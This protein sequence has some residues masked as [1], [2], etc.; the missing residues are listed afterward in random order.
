[1]SLPW[2]RCTS[3]GW[4]PTTFPSACGGPNSVTE[5]KH[6]GGAR[7]GDPCGLAPDLLP[8]AA[9]RSGCNPPAAWKESAE[10]Y[11]IASLT[12]PSVPITAFT[13]PARQAVVLARGEA[14][15]LGQDGAG[16]EHLL[17]GFGL[18]GVSNATSGLTNQGSRRQPVTTTVR[19][20]PAPR[21]TTQ[22]AATPPWPPRR[23]SGSHGRALAADRRALGFRAEERP[24]V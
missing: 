14:H 19:T 8:V 9:P 11:A 12:A 17:L 21:A 10:R 22:A 24:L 5:G 15:T 2:R 7:A 4:W 18:L 3:L 1:L 23:R 16:T 13:E 20:S 6:R